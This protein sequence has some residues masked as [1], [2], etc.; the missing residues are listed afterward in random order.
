MPIAPTIAIAKMVSKTAEV[1]AV[2]RKNTPN[3]RANPK[4][5]SARVATHATAGIKAFGR[6]QLSCAA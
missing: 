1:K 2:V 5:A 6:N 3:N 4:M